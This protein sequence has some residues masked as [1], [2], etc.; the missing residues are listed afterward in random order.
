[1]VRSRMLPSLARGPI[2]LF[3]T[4][5]FIGHAGCENAEDEVNSVVVSGPSSAGDLRMRYPSVAPRVL[6]AGEELRT[7]TTGW[8]RP[9]RSR[10]RFAPVGRLEVAFPPRLE[11]GVRLVAPG[12]EG[13]AR[14][15]VRV[16]ELR[17]SGG[18]DIQPL[19]PRI[20]APRVSIQSRAAAYERSGGWSFWSADSN[21]AEEWLLIPARE[22]DEDTAAASWRIEGAS[23]RQR[24][25]A[26]DLVDDR[27]QVRITVNAPRAVT[28]SGRTV[29]P[30]LRVE[31]DRIELLVDSGG[32]EVLVDPHWIPGGTLVVGRHRHA[33]AKL[34]NG[35]VLVVGGATGNTTD[36]IAVDAFDPI[37][38][39]WSSDGTLSAP[40]ERL[41]ATALADG[42]MLVTGGSQDSSGATYI[43]DIYDPTTDSWSLGPPLSSPRTAHAAVRLNDGRV[44][45]G[46]NSTTANVDVF[47]PATN[48]WSSAASQSFDISYSLTLLASGKVFYTALNSAASYDPA[49]DAWS[50][51]ASPG[52]QRGHTA[53]LLSNGLVLIA[54]GANVS[55]NTVSTSRVFNPATNTWSTVGS[56]SNPRIFHTATRLP[57]G[58][59]LVA[60]GFNQ[61]T[62]VYSETAELYDPAS[63]TWTPTDSL[64]TARSL[65]TATALDDG[66]VLICG[67]ATSAAGDTPGCEL[68]ATDQGDGCTADSECVS[69]Y[70]TQ[71]VCCDG[72]CDAGA[73][74]ACSTQ[75]GA[76]TDGQCTQL[77]GASCGQSLPSPTWKTMSPMGT[78]RKAPQAVVLQD[79]RVFVIGGFADSGAPL[80]TSELYDPSSD[81]WS[82]GPLLQGADGSRPSVLLQDGRVLIV[83][84]APAAPQVYDPVTNSLT[85]TGPLPSPRSNSVPVLL[86]DGRVLLV[87]GTS[88]GVDTRPAEIYDPV[89]N[90]WTLAAP[91]ARQRYGHVAQRLPDG[92][93]FVTG[94]QGI[95]NMATT[96]IYDPATDVW[97]FHSPMPHAR[98]AA[99][100]ALL[101]SGKVLV[102]GGESA[103][104]TLATADLYD[105]ATDT[106]SSAGTMHV[107]SYGA[108]AVRLLD[109]RVLIEGGRND[110]TDELADAEIYDEASNQWFAAA[111]LATARDRHAAVRLPNGDV[112][113]LGGGYIGATDTVELYSTLGTSCQTTAQ[114][115]EGQTCVD[116]VCCE[117]A[118]DEPCFACSTAGGSSAD[119]DCQPISNTACDDGDACS[120]N[121]SCEDGVCE[122]GSPVTCDA[123]KECQQGGSC[124]PA[125][126]GCVYD[127]KADGTPCSA[128]VCDNGDCVPSGSTSTAGGANSAS[129]GSGASTASPGGAGEGG[130]SAADA[131]DGPSSGCSCGVRGGDARAGFGLVA[132]A[133]LFAR[134]RTTVGQPPPHGARP[135]Q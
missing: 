134:R 79:G 121:D 81:S 40:R 71:G 18:A 124:N 103:G 86:A 28:L 135:R 107:P 95:E 58:K 21:G 11:E 115:F 46:G 129:G 125:S 1:M 117:S 120:M 52:P 44:L 30:R 19:A 31:A 87:G 38:R 48:T 102:A 45:V 54:G 22:A 99:A 33:A 10:G 2:A 53:T 29:M 37:T 49:T 39:G 24:E 85:A 126:G 8:V 15:S 82:D 74:E 132:L 88:L 114:C 112:L 83:N 47:D 111:S 105:P 97:A 59:V 23:L 35:R 50:T 122:P 60:G 9:T 128:G 92:R 90:A 7:D 62:G 91:L 63:G 127:S 131:D 61:D 17:A 66:G 72:P 14:L 70:C 118:C 6:D 27:G 32:E 78:A 26:I 123:P 77:T 3:A 80:S 113:A 69:G 109:G 16:T 55:S 104:P 64:G 57:N 73:C 89:T 110:T 51:A 98:G 106:W 13:G 25:S 119:G 100:G 130:R 56:M 96:E 34:A 76:T 93:V 94:G 116:G 65:H 133:L 12:R 101:V 5:L 84:R 41:T 108:R 20:G 42:R 68:Y 75:F 36:T 43:V 67:G 4:A